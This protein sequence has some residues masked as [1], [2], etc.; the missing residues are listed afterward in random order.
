MHALPPLTAL[1]A[2]F[3][4]CH[5]G[6]YTAAAQELCITHGAVSRHIQVVE[7]W[8]GVNLFTKEGQRR[9]PT[10]YA[11]TLARELGSAFDTLSDIAL[12]YGNGGR[13]NVFNV[14]VPTTM[15]LKWLL[16]RLDDFYARFPAANLQIST[17]NTEQL[18]IVGHY[19]L[20]IRRELS[21]TQYSAIPFLGDTH[22]LMASP[23]L[24]SRLTIKKPED[25]LNCLRIETLTRPG[26]WNL[27]LAA[28]GLGKAP[29]SG[30]R[31]YDH[32]HVSLH[33]M[34]EGMGVGLGPVSTLSA[35]ISRGNLVPL[36]PEITVAPCQ[37]FALTPV[38]VQKTLLHQAFE[39]WLVEQGQ[40]GDEKAYQS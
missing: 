30:F 39:D 29:V 34:L 31:R 21:A 6:S 22:C 18:H 17:A 27:W 15:S 5:A 2:F 37:Y 14:S 38:G 32:F 9:V 36:F 20:L 25:V 13:N 40:S 16:P 19:D 4:A 35:E 12:R 28:A 23:A 33:A 7:K 24:L 1:R 26:H 3:V 11:L 10:P 8:F